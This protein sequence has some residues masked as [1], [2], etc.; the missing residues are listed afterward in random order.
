MA[1]AVYAMSEL[2]RELITL[3]F[4]GAELG[5]SQDFYS[6]LRP[7]FVPVAQDLDGKVFEATTLKVELN[8]RYGISVPED[9]CDFLVGRLHSQGM[10]ARGRGTEHSSLFYWKAA[11]ETRAYDERATGD[12]LDQLVSELV[13]FRETFVSL[14]FNEFEGAELLAILVEYLKGTDQALE[15]ALGALGADAPQVTT[16]G[17]K[18]IF[19]DE[20]GYFCSRFLENLSKGN[21]NV[22]AWVARLSTAVLVSEVVLSLKEPPGHA[23]KLSNAH[24]YLDAPLLLELVG[25]SG[26]DRRTSAK[27][28]VDK[29]VAAGASV[30]VLD[31]SIEEAQEALSALRDKRPNQRHGPT[32]AAMARGEVTDLFLTTVISNFDHFVDEAGVKRVDTSVARFAANQIA[33]FSDKV[34]RELEGRLL[35]GYTTSQRAAERDA[36]SVAFVM[37]AR[38]RNKV[39]R[40][41]DAKHLLLTRNDALQATVASFMKQAGLLDAGELGPTLLA[42]HITAFI[43]LAA[44]DKDKVEIDVRN[45]LIQSDRVVQSSPAA[46]ES[47]RAKL[48]EISPAN[49]QTF[50]ALMQVPRCYQLALDLV[51]GSVQRALSTNVEEVLERVKRETTAEVTAEHQQ[52][53]S[54]ER[55][56]HKRQAAELQ[57]RSEQAERES[58]ALKAEL[59]RTAQ[60]EE[61]RAQRIF[62]S[63]ADMR[64]RTIY[65]AK[66]LGTSLAVGWFFL[67]L[68]GLVESLEVGA[69]LGMLASAGV[70]ASIWFGA[71]Y[72]NR[73]FE[74]LWRGYLQRR[75]HDAG[76]EYGGRDTAWPS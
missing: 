38:G 69:A 75:L 67:G 22:M 53:L 54:R 40:I 42:D 25:T 14:V 27:Y 76:V 44:G 37:R 33:A 15:N 65:Y 60:G 9:V 10:L 23:L 58:E 71:S 46:I 16:V 3:A 61:A 72:W 59:Q 26:N 21:P 57:A 31:H 7:L 18:R 49:A 56:R 52:R 64:S 36:M 51:G 2:R 35:S 70:V 32:H 50:E 29:L 24:Y 45:L 74:W 47:L 6:A 28:T 20:K 63:V 17:G 55:D 62:Q 41:H 34:T 48:A 4:V 39:V 66:W 11:P 13:A 30:R 43:W 73:A 68:N 5:T 1:G 12:A 19:R 8:R